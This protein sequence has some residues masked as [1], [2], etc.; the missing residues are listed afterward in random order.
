MLEKNVQYLKE[1]YLKTCGMPTLS[2]SIRTR[3][4]TATAKTTKVPHF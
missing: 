4:V 3:A 1:Q 2:L